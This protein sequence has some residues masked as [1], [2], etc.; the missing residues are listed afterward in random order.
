MLC[1]FIPQSASK[2]LD[3]LGIKENERQLHYVLDSHMAA[4]VKLPAPEP[5][6]PRYVP[7]DEEA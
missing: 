5:V 6:F 2:L 7:K 1:P 3:L 4:G